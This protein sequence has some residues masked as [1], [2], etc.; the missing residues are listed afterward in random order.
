MYQICPWMRFYGI[1]FLPK[2]K[3]TLTKYS[4]RIRL[5]TMEGETGGIFNNFALHS[6][7][8]PA[9]IDDPK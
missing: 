1:Y 8:L 9:A 3:L 7:S 2:K 4:T 6:V 5:L